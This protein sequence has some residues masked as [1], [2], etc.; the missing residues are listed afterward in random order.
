MLSPHEANTTI[1]VRMFLRSIAVPRVVTMSP[2]AR[3]LPTKRLL[4]MKR[5]SS[6]FIR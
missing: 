3:R 1:G 2:A 4:T 5:I 6:A